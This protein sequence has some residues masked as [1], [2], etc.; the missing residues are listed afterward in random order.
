[1]GYPVVGD[2]LYTKKKDRFGLKGQL[3]HAYKLGL[4]HPVTN[5]Y[6][7]FYAPLPEHFQKVLD[8][9]EKNY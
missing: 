7:E 1:L 5:E 3:L 8:Y 2:K 9:L 6:M 4:Y